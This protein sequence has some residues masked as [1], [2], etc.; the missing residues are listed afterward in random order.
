M[1]PQYLNSF[2]WNT[3]TGV[4]IAIWVFVLLVVAAA[5][6][7]LLGK[8]AIQSLVYTHALPDQALKVRFFFYAISVIVLLALG[9]VFWSAVANSVNVLNNYFPR[10]LL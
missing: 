3:I 9:Y 2:D 4:L 6:S 10:W 5:F 1:V 8:G 7:F